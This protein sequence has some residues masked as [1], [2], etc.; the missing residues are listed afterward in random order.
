MPSPL[1]RDAVRS[2]RTVS[3]LPPSRDEHETIGGLF[4]VALSVALPRLDVIQPAAHGSSD[5]PPRLAT[6][7][8]S[9]PLHV[10]SLTECFR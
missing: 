4:S 9:D 6:R 3:P 5:F 8:S 2:Y 7:R 10:S 1:T